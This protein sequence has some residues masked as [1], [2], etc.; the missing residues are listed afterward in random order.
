MEIKENKLGRTYLKGKAVVSVHETD[1]V[2][3]ELE[4]INK[5]CD[6]ITKTLPCELEHLK[7]VHD[8][9]D[10]RIERNESEDGSQVYEVA[11]GY[12]LKMKEEYNKI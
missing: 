1:S 12:E 8:G 11:F 5:A 4:G 9:S 6:E 7:A 2:R 3:T 10:F